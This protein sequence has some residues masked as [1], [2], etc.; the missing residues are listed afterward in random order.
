MGLGASTSP[1]TRREPRCLGRE[2]GLLPRADLSPAIIPPGARD[3]AGS[4]A[5][6]Q[7]DSPLPGA[8]GRGG[9]VLLCCPASTGRG[10][11]AC[12]GSSQPPQCHQCFPPAPRQRTCEL[13][14]GM[15]RCTKGAAAP[16]SSAE[17]PRGH[18]P[19]PAYQRGGGREGQN[20]GEEQSEGLGP[21]V[22]AAP[23]AGAGAWGIGRGAGR[24]HGSGSTGEEACKKQWKECTQPAPG[25]ADSKLPL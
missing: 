24:K 1:C 8:G 12:P 20:T 15:A 4:R 7:Q 6:H 11:P 16:G 22:N 17:P 9:G 18:R 3:G 10:C 25:A 19:A 13:M 14:T 23:G 21:G 5:A 2:G